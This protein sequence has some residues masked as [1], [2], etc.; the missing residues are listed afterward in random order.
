MGLAGLSVTIPFFSL[1]PGFRACYLVVCG[2]VLVVC[3][4]VRPVSL[5]T[6]LIKEL[7]QKKRRGL[8]RYQSISKWFLFFQGFARLT[9]SDFVDDPSAARFEG[10]AQ[11]WAGG[12]GVVLIV[13]LCV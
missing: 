3:L 10:D 7:K 5:L 9:Y 6:G 4:R 1:L 12:C 11:K 13:C 2:V 8:E